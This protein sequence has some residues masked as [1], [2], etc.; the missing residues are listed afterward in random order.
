[1]SKEK[2]VIFLRGK[3][4]Y[5]RPMEDCDTGRSRR[6]FNDPR[7]SEYP[8]VRWP[9]GEAREAAFLEEDDGEPP[10][11]ITLAI[12]LRKGD[13]HIGTISLMNI[14]WANRRAKTGMLIGDVK[15]RGKGYGHEAK[16]LL[17]AYAFDELDLFR[18]ESQV[19]ATNR[20]SIACLMKSGYV[21]EGRRRRSRFTRGRA[22]RAKARK[23]K[24]K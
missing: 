3:R 18:I 2:P 14:D 21:L 19:N 9:A 10:N 4:V 23:P 6:W 20:A 17:L 13:R 7:C 5:L 11:S 1:M 8:V 16:E 15:R 24:K 12:V 22:K